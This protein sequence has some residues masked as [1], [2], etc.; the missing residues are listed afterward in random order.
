MH[1]WTNSTTAPIIRSPSIVDGNKVTLRRRNYP[2]QG[3]ITKVSFVVLG[4][5]VSGLRYSFGWRL[6]IFICAG[7]VIDVALNYGVSLGDARRNPH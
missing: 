1:I 3:V 6:A 2:L 7:A 4:L 5:L